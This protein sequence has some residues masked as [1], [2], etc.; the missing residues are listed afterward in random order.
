MFV[1]DEYFS[2]PFVTEDVL[3][4]DSL[5]TWKTYTT[6]HKASSEYAIMQ[7]ADIVDVD[8]LA[9]TTESTHSAYLSEGALVQADVYMCDTTTQIS[10]KNYS[11][12]LTY[13]IS[14]NTGDEVPTLTIPKQ[15]IYD[16]ITYYTNIDATYI[17]DGLHVC[18]GLII[19]L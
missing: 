4:L 12:L 2:F 7:S 13:H 3:L 18:Q 8:I 5:E 10:D 1:T 9:N 15:F 11:H 16:S 19:F 14:W 6:R 17:T